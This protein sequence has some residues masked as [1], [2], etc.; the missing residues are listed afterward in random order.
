MMRPCWVGWISAVPG[1]ARD[2]SRQSQHR[3]A[4]SPRR[5]GSGRATDRNAP[6]AVEAL[7]AP[8]QF[9]CDHHARS[10]SAM[11]LPCAPV[12]ETSSEARTAGAGSSGVHPTATAHYYAR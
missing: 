7:W 4:E 3:D 5:G 11:L 10:G 1:A 12:P 6:L 2:G 8:P 9:V